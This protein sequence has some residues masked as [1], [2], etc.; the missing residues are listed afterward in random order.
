[1]MKEKKKKKKKKKEKKK[2]KEEQ[3]QELR[4][5][6]RCFFWFAICRAASSPPIA[7]R[8][9]AHHSR[10]VIPENSRFEPSLAT[11]NPDNFK[12]P[13][14]WIH[15]YQTCV[16]IYI[17]LIYVHMY[18]LRI[19][20]YVYDICITH[21]YTY[22]HT[23]VYTSPLILISFWVIE[24]F[25]R[26]PHQ[27]TSWYTG[28]AF[29]T[30]KEVDYGAVVWKCRVQTS[31]LKKV[32]WI[33][34][35]QPSNNICIYIYWIRSGLFFVAIREFVLFHQKKRKRDGWLFFAVA[36][37]NECQCN[38]GD[39]AGQR[40]WSR[41]KPRRCGHFKKKL[42][43]GERGRFGSTLKLW[44][45]AKGKEGR[46]MRGTWWLFKK[47]KTNTQTHNACII[48][49]TYPSIKKTCAPFWKNP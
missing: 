5:E 30:S 22:T 47:M 20:I 34:T 42:R 41:H 15:L 18:V 4:R 11:I 31:I 32:E 26:E 8:S 45:L 17:W 6:E 14:G 40:F 44:K 12:K 28:D 7:R 36:S 10:M 27:L 48:I 13:R 1:M 49:Y 2:E 9:V 19:Y 35:R 37:F 38:S 46:E 24:S 43:V 25:F 16:C 33:I 3:G 39:S 23:F 29:I 21:V